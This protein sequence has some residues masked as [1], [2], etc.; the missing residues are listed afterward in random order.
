MKLFGSE[1]N[2]K[3]SKIRLVASVAKV[4]LELIDCDS[5]KMGSADFQSSHP[6]SKK[7]TM[8]RLPF[9]TIDDQ[10]VH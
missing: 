2:N 10:V 5:K 6:V 1:T 9:M 8:K 3:V 4:D 7:N